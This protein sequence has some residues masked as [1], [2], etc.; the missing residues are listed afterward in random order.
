MK[1]DIKDRAMKEKTMTRIPIKKK[2]LWFKRKSLSLKKE[3]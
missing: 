2:E 1:K 3:L